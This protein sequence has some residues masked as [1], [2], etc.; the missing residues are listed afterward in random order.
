M[1]HHKINPLNT[2]LEFDDSLE[3]MRY[4][5]DEDKE[6]IMA[7]V[8]GVGVVRLWEGEGI[9]QYFIPT[10]EGDT[11]LRERLIYQLLRED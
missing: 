2:T 10:V 3:I 1:A 8:R 11:I 7:V 9:E 6:V 4:I 5:F